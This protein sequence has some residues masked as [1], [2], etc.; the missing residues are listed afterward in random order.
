MNVL[1]YLHIR[2]TLGQTTGVA[3]H[4]IRM[5]RG[6][7]D[8]HGFDVHLLGSRPE[9]DEQ[10]ARQPDWALADRP[11]HTFGASRSL[12]EKWWYV[13]RFPAVERYWP[14]CE[15]VYV[16]NEAYVPVRRARLAFTVHDLDYVEPNLPWSDL[17]H[18][19][20][21]RRAWLAKLVPMCRR[22]DVVLAVSE[23]T[24][25]RVVELLKVPERKVAVVGNGVDERFFRM[26]DLPAGPVDRPYLLQVGAMIDKKGAGAVLALAR[27]LAARKSPIEL[28][29]SGKIEEKFRPA[30]AALPNVRPL[31]YVSDEELAGL[32]RGAVALILLSRYE[33]FG[34]PPLEAMAAGVPA[35]VSHHASLP[36][37]VGDAATVVDPD[38]PE[39]AADAAEQLLA[40]A[41]YRATIIRRGQARVEGYRW[42]ACV[43]RLARAMTG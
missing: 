33:G 15:W 18:V 11:M 35:I 41:G 21:A 2:R 1:T 17:P 28:W 12:M 14:A 40:D 31:G 22:A 29:V 36:E 13:A 34:M 6:L 39:T 10:R 23:F 7:V 3:R 26:A 27:E 4:A 24:R 5:V 43:D 38:R 8:R 32:L 42:S 25:Q 37:V 16:P 19:R 30:V 9:H 20:K